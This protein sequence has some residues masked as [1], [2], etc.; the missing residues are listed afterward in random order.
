MPAYNHE[1]Y[2]EQAIKSIWTQDYK[3]V[4]IVVVDDCSQD[5]TFET[6]C[7]LKKKSPVNMTVVKNDKNMG[8][9]YT[10]KRAYSLSTGGYIAFLASDDYVC[11]NRFS[12]QMAYFEGSDALKV[13]YANGYRVASDEKIRKVHP[14]S[15]NLIFTKTPK[16]ILEFL[17]T[18]INPIFIQTM[19]AKKEFFNNFEFLDEK[20]IADDWL[21]NTRVFENLK[22]REEFVYIDEPVFNYRIHSENIHKNV[23]RHVKLMSNYVENITPMHLKKLAYANIYF[24]IGFKYLESE[25]YS[26]SFRF[27][28]KSMAYKFQLSKFKLIRKIF[29]GYLKSIY[30]KS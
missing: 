10:L 12:H 4:E 15:V 29:K 9:N 8:I 1:N 27:W 11:R 16:Q 2:V 13:V 25:A 23:D 28:R 30:L 24:T 26:D 20:I 22:S 14:E 19:L 17:Y 18:T 6:L 7:D 5:A 21:L 3:N